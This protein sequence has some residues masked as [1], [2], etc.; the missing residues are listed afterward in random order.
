[1]T[2]DAP[3]LGEV[4]RRIDAAVT[5][6]REMRREI[7]DDRRRMTA[8]FL[9][10]ETAE[11]REATTALQIA[12]LEKEIHSTGKRL[13]TI[14]SNRRQDRAL[15][16]GNLAFPLLVILLGAVLLARGVG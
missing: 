5:E 16:L 1:V 6:L 9:S 4:V 3:T 2:D 12:G 13:D 14:E 10:K 7:A 11:E 15:L 8:E